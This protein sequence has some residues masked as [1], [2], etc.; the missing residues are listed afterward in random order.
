MAKRERDKLNAMNPTTPDQEESKIGTLIE[1]PAG[2]TMIVTEFGPMPLEP[3][4]T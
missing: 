2:K 1:G 4:P 3:L